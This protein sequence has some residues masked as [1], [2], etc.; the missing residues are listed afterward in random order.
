MEQ[1]QKIIIMS[2][3]E[4]LILI[5]SVFLVVYSLCLNICVIIFHQAVIYIT[6]LLNL[7]LVN[8]LVGL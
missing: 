7:F 6:S 3:L 5:L 4:Y 2:C 1:V 8:L